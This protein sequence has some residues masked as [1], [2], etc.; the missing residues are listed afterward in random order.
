MTEPTE[1]RWERPPQRIVVPG[2]PARRDV[3]E[4]PEDFDGVAISE[5]QQV[6][7]LGSASRSC[8]AIL[9]AMLVIAL[10]VCVFLLWVAFIR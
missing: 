6:R 1:E 7:D 10:L 8:V 3:A 2:V 9:A 5:E 4:E